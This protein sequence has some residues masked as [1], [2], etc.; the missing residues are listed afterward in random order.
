MS[1]NNRLKT[2]T[3]GLLK[4]NPVFVLLL[5]TCPSLAVTTMAQNG[6][7]M[8]FATLFVLLGSNIVIS[9]LRKII[10][11]KV[12]IPCYIVVI[13]GF[14]T[15][16]GMFL[17]AFA[18]EL[19]AQLGIYIPL[20]VVNCI[21]LGRAEAFASKNSLFDSILDAI[22]MGLGFTIALIVIGS[23]REIIGNGT[24]FGITLF[25]TAPFP[26]FILPPGGFFVFGITIAVVTMI[27]KGK[28]PN[29]SIG[30]AACPSA[31]VCGH[32]GE[33]DCTAS[34][35]ERSAD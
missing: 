26:L 23:I 10:P 4:E 25:E 6:I 19:D 7:G 32:A 8:G 18:P 29:K 21:I 9:L 13:A 30:C 20:I 35:K 22:G 11:D 24:W 3:N 12:R 27:T 28:K 17:K 34:S 14:V 5:G 1:N 2:L 33:G 31:S 15:I 16:V